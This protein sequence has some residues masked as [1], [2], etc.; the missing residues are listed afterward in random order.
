MD[1][2]GIDAND[3]R[4]VEKTYNILDTRK[5]NGRLAA[6]SGIDHGKKRSRDINIGDATFETSGDKATNVGD[7]TSAEIDEKGMTVGMGVEKRLA[8]SRGDV[9]RLGGL[10]HRG[11]KDRGST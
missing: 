2:R 1:E 6:D 5:I 10:T 3:R 9:E 8:K 11:K 7:T 4:R